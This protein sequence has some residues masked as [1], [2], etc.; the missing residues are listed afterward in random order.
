MWPATF[1]KWLNMLSLFLEVSA[2]HRMVSRMPPTN[3]SFIRKGIPSR[4]KKDRVME[5]EARILVTLKTSFSVEDV[6]YHR[7]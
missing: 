2:P 3:P 1:M 6:R 7:S 5:R 4:K